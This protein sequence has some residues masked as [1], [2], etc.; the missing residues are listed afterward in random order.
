MERKSKKENLLDGEL[1]SLIR[2]GI[3][4]RIHV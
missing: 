2:I 1:K 4:V 3:S